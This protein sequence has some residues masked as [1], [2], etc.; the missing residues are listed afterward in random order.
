MPAGM[1]S[2]TFFIIYIV[3]F[4][5]IMYLLIFLPQKRRDKKV[6]E[7][8]NSLEEGNTIITIGGLS[9]KIVNIKDDD[10]TVESGVD[11]TKVLIK[12]WAVKEVEKSPQA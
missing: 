2:T 1:N 11:K 4:I 8:L 6:K 3:F 7:M 9:G 12:K 5:A 10:L